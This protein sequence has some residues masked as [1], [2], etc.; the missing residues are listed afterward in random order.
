MN[1]SPFPT[2][3]NIDIQ[4]SRSIQ[5]ISWTWRTIYDED[6]DLSY[7]EEQNQ[8]YKYLKLKP[9]NPSTER[10][11]VMSCFSVKTMSCSGDIDTA[12]VWPHMGDKRSSLSGETFLST[13]CESCRGPLRT[14][15]MSLSLGT[16]DWEPTSR[17]CPGPPAVDWRWRQRWLS[18]SQTETELETGKCPCLH[19]NPEPHKR[20]LKPFGC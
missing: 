12:G 13:D 4:K 14:R 8:S 6:G 11:R 15:H 18:R 7:F 1:S 3:N 9:S 5:N 10:S 16:R 20:N 19:H 17:T 2:S